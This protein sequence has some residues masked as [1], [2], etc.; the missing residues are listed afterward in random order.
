MRD[1]DRPPYDGSVQRAI[2]AQL[3]EARTIG[4]VSAALQWDYERV[5]RWVHHLR[6]VQ[7]IKALGRIWTSSKRVAVVYQRVAE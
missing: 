6:K 7:K 2:L 4:D 5:C 1:Q 3:N